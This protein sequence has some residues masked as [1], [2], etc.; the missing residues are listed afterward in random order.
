MS[1]AQQRQLPPEDMPQFLNKPQPVRPSQ[2][3][4]PPPDVTV[5]HDDE[6]IPTP[7]SVRMTEYLWPTLFWF[8]AF[9][10]TAVMMLAVLNISTEGYN[11]WVHAQAGLVTVF[12]TGFAA[13][14]VKWI[15]NGPDGWPSSHRQTV[16]APPP[17]S[18]D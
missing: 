8:M 14:I 15:L 17:K 9:F 6:D 11:V 13:L 18:D 5:M 16:L 2:R 1:M 4:L 12:L 7:F 10:N 3:R